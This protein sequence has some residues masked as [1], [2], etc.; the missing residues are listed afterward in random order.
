MCSVVYALDLYSCVYSYEVITIKKSY[1]RGLSTNKQWYKYRAGHVTA[2]TIYR[3]CRTDPHRPSVSMTKQICYT[4]I[5]VKPKTLAIEHGCKHEKDGKETCKTKLTSVQSNF[6]IEPCEF[7][8]SHQN[9]ILGALPDALVTCKC[10]CP[11]VLEV[12]CPIA[13]WSAD[14]CDSYSI[15][16]MSIAK[17]EEVVDINVKLNKAMHKIVFFQITVRHM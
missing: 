4:E 12:K 7:I 13:M 3:V 10:G 14:L 2:S 1:T 15:V 17:M 6:V 5:T 11:G 9:S 8:V 16:V